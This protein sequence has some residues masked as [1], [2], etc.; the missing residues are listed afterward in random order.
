MTLLQ[1]MTNLINSTNPWAYVALGVI[2]TGEAFV[3]TTFAVSGVIA[4]VAVGALAANGR[5]DLVAAFAAIYVGTLLGDTASFLLS[6][7][8]QR[9][10]WLSALMSRLSGRRRMLAQTPWRF[11]ATAHFT[12]YL[13]GVAATLA[14]G[15]LSFSEWIRIELVCAALGA[16]YF[17]GLGYAGATM[18]RALNTQAVPGLFGAGGLILLVTFY[19]L[20]NDGAGAGKRSPLARLTYLGRQLFFWIWFPFWHPVRWL[21]GWLRGL[22][23]RTLRRDLADSFPDVRPGDIFLV[24]LHA[25]SPWGTWAHSAIAVDH[26]RFAHGF[27]DQITAHSMAALPIRYAIAHLRVKCP[28]RNGAIAANFAKAQIGKAVSI[29]AKP[30]DPQ[31][32][33]CCSLLVAAY[34][35]AGV[36]LVENPWPRIVPGDLLTSPNTELVRLVYTEQ[37]RAGLRSRSIE[38]IAARKA[39]L[40]WRSGHAR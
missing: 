5:L 38:K 34:A 19:F 18:F 28:P 4:F 23:T 22:P 10:R 14:A 3:L 25:M 31:R 29:F 39:K 7:R 13:R 9:L 37:V 35:H 40:R 6:A 11:L 36:S 21:E 24:R 15:S 8:L 2:A 26:Q 30:G 16:A 1:A 20:A 33:S 32:F 27:S 17:M 12:P